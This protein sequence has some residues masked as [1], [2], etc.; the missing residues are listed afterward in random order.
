MM[1]VLEEVSGSPKSLRHIIWEQWMSVQHFVQIHLVEIE[2]FHYV[3]MI[4]PPAKSY[5]SPSSSWTK[6]VDGQNHKLLLPFIELR[7]YWH[8]HTVN[9]L[10]YIAKKSYSTWT[11]HMIVVNIRINML[12]FKQV[13]FLPMHPAESTF[14]M[15][16]F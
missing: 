6:V 3:I 10:Q 4:H 1:L 13:C 5:G 14:R 16:I 12:L 7:H 2:I 9:K 8:T 15:E 11:I